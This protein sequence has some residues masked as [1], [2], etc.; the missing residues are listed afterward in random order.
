MT[1]LTIAGSPAANSRAR[2]IAEFVT[3]RFDS[4]GVEAGELDLRELPA[5]A[6]LRLDR[7]HRGLQAALARVA[8]ASAIVI[9]TP[10]YKSSY[11]GLLKTFL[12]L[13]P[14]AGLKGKAVLAIAT[15]GATDQALAVDFSLQP[16]LAALHARYVLGSIHTLDQQVSWTPET[17][18][19]LDADVASRID[20]GV[21]HLV[22]ST[23]P[24]G[25][26]PTPYPAAEAFFPVDPLDP[27]L[28]RCWD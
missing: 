23:R 9:V 18:L 1:A 14:Q 24:H 12:D 17:G 10:V 8:S 11:S 4:W 7:R 16:V 20:E 5:E 25:L 13:L 28:V 6:L 2:R 26:L 21:R 15:A 3:T 27:E 19:Q 22:N